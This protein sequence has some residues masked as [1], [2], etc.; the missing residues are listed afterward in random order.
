MTKT[1]II[2]ISIVSAFIVAFGYAW[3]TMTNFALENLNNDRVDAHKN[4]KVVS[5]DAFYNVSEAVANVAHSALPDYLS[6]LLPERIMDYGF[7]SKDDLEK[8]YLL[9]P[10][11]A[12][13]PNR[14]NASLNQ[15]F[16]EQY[17]DGA[18]TIWFVPVAVGNSIACLIEINLDEYNKP[19]AVSFGSSYK[20]K[21]IESGLNLLGWP[22]FNRWQDLRILSFYGPTVDFLLS[23]ESNGQWKW[24]NLTGT[25]NVKPITLDSVGISKV[26]I[27]INNTKSTDTLP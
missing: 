6:K 8:A 24:L 23:K 18:S 21:R 22:N 4:L 25:S 19:R 2:A 9:P 3:P 20:A 10:I 5:P 26:L 1:V 16:I 11:P 7:Q 15:K 17:I 14:A 12:F 13:M 27:T